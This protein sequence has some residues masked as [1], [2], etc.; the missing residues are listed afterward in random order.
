MIISGFN[1]PP[2]LTFGTLTQLKDLKV[3]CNV[4]I[5]PQFLNCFVQL[6]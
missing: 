5:L 3:T 2:R 4:N 1:I 6:Y